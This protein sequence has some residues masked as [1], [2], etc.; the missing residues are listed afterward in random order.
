MITKNVIKILLII[1][2]LALPTFAQKRRTTPAPRPPAATSQQFEQAKTKA[3]QAREAGNLDEA[4][5]LYRKAISYSHKWDEGWWYLATLLYEKDQY[6]EAVKAFNNAAALNPKSGAP[7]V[8]MALCEFR[9]GD[10]DN[11][12]VHM[13]Q[14]RQRGVGDNPELKKVMRF[15]EGMLLLLKSE[16][17][18]AQKIFNSLSYDNV[19]TEQLFIATGLSIL[20]IPSLP[21]Q[22]DLKHPDYQ[23][24]RRAGYAQHLVAQLNTSDGQ[25][26]YDRL[27]ADFAKTPGIFYAFGRYQLY[28]QRNPDAA[29]EAFKKEIENSPTHAL[30]RLQ[31]A[32]I[33]INNKEPQDGVKLAEEGVKLNP[34]L[35]LGHY[36]LGRLY[37]DTGEN[38]RAIEELEIAQRMSPDEAKIYFALARAYSK[39]GRKADADQ[40]RQNFTRLNA[41]AEAAAANGQGRATAIEENEEKPKQ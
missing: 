24:I 17:E 4:I 19:N 35:S 27:A 33:K 20:R 40:A 3:N 37:L 5:D 34:R 16:F 26:E 31:I 18:M 12:L 39:A 28:Q 6:P 25:R 21:S 30:A 1:I 38:P 41:A 15:H 7:I 14:G 36:I 10:Y 29:I 23:M 8:M 13:I 32:Y 22:I 2:V 11:A 9:L